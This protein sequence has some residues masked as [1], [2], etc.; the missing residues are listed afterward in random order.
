MDIALVVIGA[1]IALAGTVLARFL[2]SKWRR[3]DK[4]NEYIAKLEVDA[5]VWI[6][7]LFKKIMYYLD[8][9]NKEDP[10][11]EEAKK[12]I[13]DNNDLFW[14]KRLLFP[15]GVPECWMACRNAVE[16]EDGEKATNQA[17]IAFPIICKR[18]GLEEFP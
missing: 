15:P 11:F 2:D 13:R 18:F 12:I 10:K 17:Q 1:M 7:P 8:H 5:C 14:E 9:D 4:R 6:Y 3:K 16:E